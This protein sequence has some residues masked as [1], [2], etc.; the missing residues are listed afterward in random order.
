MAAVF[1]LQLKVHFY[2][3]RNSKN[4]INMEVIFIKIDIGILPRRYVSDEPES[5][6]FFP[7]AID[8]GASYLYDIFFVERKDE[9]EVEV[10]VSKWMKVLNIFPIYIFV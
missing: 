7:F 9:K 1:L 10:F 8:G 6:G 5:G 3:K 4:C 2:L